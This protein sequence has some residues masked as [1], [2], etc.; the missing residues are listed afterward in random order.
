MSVACAHNLTLHYTKRYLFMTSSPSSPCH[1]HA[2]IVVAQKKAQNRP[3]PLFKVIDYFG[4]PQFHTT[5]LPK[6][7][8][9]KRHVPK[10]QTFF[11]FL[12]DHHRR[13]DGGLDGGLYHRLWWRRHAHI[14]YLNDSRRF[15]V[16]VICF[17]SRPKPSR[18]MNEWQE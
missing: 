5:N 11:F 1:H 15:H 10:L 4:Q 14:S 17:K 8:T 12:L 3:L 7:I 2:P 13:L 6:L 9:S 18:K 16:P